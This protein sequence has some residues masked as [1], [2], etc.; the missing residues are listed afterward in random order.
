MM[1]M[2]AQMKHEKATKAT[3]RN[4]DSGAGSSRG[5]PSTSSRRLDDLDDLKMLKDLMDL[6]DLATSSELKDRGSHLTASE[7]RDEC[8]RLRL[9]DTGTRAEMLKRIGEFERA[10][11]EERRVILLGH[12]GLVT[13]DVLKGLLKRHLISY[14][15]KAKREEL[16]RLAIDNEI[17][18]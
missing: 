17:D 15:S 7:L 1:V 6:K 14:G 16:V 10:S 3:P 11:P 2:D 5:T 18:P 12:K 9:Y 8:K 13:T 4:N